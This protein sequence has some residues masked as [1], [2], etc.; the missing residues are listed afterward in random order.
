MWVGKDKPNHEQP[1]TSLQV[2]RE[3]VRI[4]LLGLKQQN[5]LYASISID[6]NLLNEWPQSFIPEELLDSLVLIQDVD[7]ETAKRSGYADDIDNSDPVQEAELE[8]SAEET[9]STSGMSSIDSQND[10]AGA[11]LVSALLLSSN[12]HCE[13]QQHQD[14]RVQQPLI[15][16]RTDTNDIVN[17][18]IE[19]GLFPG[20]F[21][22][23]FWH[24]QKG[25]LDQSLID[26]KISFTTWLSYLLR[27]HTRRFSRHPTFIHVAFDIGTHHK[28]NNAASILVKCRDWTKRSKEIH[29]LTEDQLKIATHQLKNNL[30]ITIEPVFSLLSSCITLGQFIPLS[31]E[32]RQRMRANIKANIVQFGLLAVWLTINP[33]D[34]CHPILCKIAGISLSPKLN[35]TPQQL[36]NLKARSATTNPVASAQFFHIM[37]TRFFNTPVIPQDNLPGVFEDIESYFSTTETNGR[38]SL[39]LHGFLWLRGNIGIETLRKRILRNENGRNTVYSSLVNVHILILLEK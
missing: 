10:G 14:N 16:I 37:I 33:S 21:S 23:L 39:H 7:G 29:G 35:L 24:T 5:P 13:P 6:H 11:S 36:Q 26:N 32:N 18:Y 4:A 17:D 27:H 8:F 2:R 25:H 3:V 1:G 28:V 15:Q 20:T 31:H 34:L 12:M 22:T 30:P 9:F 38:G 19:A